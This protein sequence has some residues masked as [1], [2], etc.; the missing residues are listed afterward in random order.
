MK[1]IFS[2][3]FF[4]SGLFSVFSQI[5]N[6][7]EEFLLPPHVIE[8]SGAIFFN[9]KLITHTDSEGE[10]KLYELDITT[11]QITRT[12]TITNATNIDWEDITQD[13][14]SIYIGDIGNN[15]GSRTDLKI[16]KICKTDYLNST[17]VTAEIINY[18]YSGQTDFT[19]KPNNTIWD[20]E[21][22]V[23]F[24]SDNLL[25]FTKNW[26]DGITKSYIIPKTQGTHVVSPQLSTLN[27]N[28]L[29]SGGTYNTTSGKLYLT[30]YD[31]VLNPFVWMSDSF[32]TNDIFSGTNT[33][34]SLTSLGFEQIEAIAFIDENS[35][36]MSSES[37]SISSGLFTLSDNAKLISFSTS[38][39]ELSTTT[40]ASMQDLL[41]YP[42]PSSNIV[43]IKCNPLSSIEIF[44]TQNK[45]IHHGIENK[46]DISHLSVGVYFIKACFKNSACDIEKFVKQ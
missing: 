15:N 40:N 39:K 13:D 43:H 32:N 45:K 6:V 30:G 7:T 23:S 42:N 34:T 16:Y 1:V 41:V 22:L 3:L 18:R 11:E 10:N 12:V 36:L 20:A 28:G 4:I 5:I 37:F 2:I 25:L 35:Y 14:T 46:I 8:S 21:A 33:Q 26:I 38:D 27:S 19:P 29:I 31:N 9:N 44:D 17:N 24:D